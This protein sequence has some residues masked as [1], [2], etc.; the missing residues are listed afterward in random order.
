[1]EN[2]EVDFQDLSFKFQTESF[3]TRTQTKQ[4]SDKIHIRHSSIHN[5]AHANDFNCSIV[6]VEISVAL[7]CHFEVKVLDSHR[8]SQIRCVQFVFQF[9]TTIWDCLPHFIFLQFAIG[10]A[11]LRL[12]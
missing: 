3:I 4:H 5:E 2:G 11:I 9:Y 6:K 1:M 8:L 10:H 7:S 12:K